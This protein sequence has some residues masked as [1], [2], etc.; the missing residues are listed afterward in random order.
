MNLLL[1]ASINQGPGSGGP[2]FLA[3]KA[4]RLQL[5]LLPSITGYGFW[6]ALVAESGSLKFT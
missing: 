2:F 4:A 1:E 6:Q 3:P 5:A